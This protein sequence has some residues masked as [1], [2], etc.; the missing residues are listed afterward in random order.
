MAYYLDLSGVGN[1]NFRIV[2]PSSFL[3]IGL[4][5]GT[6]NLDLTP[7]VSALGESWTGTGAGGVLVEDPTDPVN[8]LPS[9]LVLGTNRTTI[10][11]GMTTNFD[12]NSI[13]YNGNG[14][15]LASLHVD[16]ENLDAIAS[17]AF[18]DQSTNNTHILRIACDPVDRQGLP[19]QGTA[20][21]I[22][23]VEF[24]ANLRYSGVDGVI[25]TSTGNL[26][27]ARDAD[28][29]MNDRQTVFEIPFQIPQG[30]L[31]AV[32]GRRYPNLELYI[33][34]VAGNSGGQAN[35]SFP[36]FNAI[37]IYLNVLDID[38]YDFQNRGYLT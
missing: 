18:G 34:Q 26:I 11:T 5:G 25:L 36:R 32:G 12:N 20:G 16:F 30:S 17:P 29:V 13:L 23:Q 19:Q 7:G 2:K 37:E 14:Q 10:S 6:I 3:N 1:N 27:V 9:S 31:S 22:D 21:N 24:I 15:D 8:N 38:P 33:E 28:Q 4:V 35:R